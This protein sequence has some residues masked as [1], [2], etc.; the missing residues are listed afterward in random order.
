[1]VFDWIKQFFWFVREKLVGTV[2]WNN[3]YGFSFLDGRVFLLLIPVLLLDWGQ[4]RSKEETFFTKWP[5]WGKAL[6]LAI[7]AIVLVLLSF[8]GTGA[9][10]VYQGF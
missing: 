10:F 3:W 9:P 5:V 4:S 1:M 7:L 6:F 8:A 2:A